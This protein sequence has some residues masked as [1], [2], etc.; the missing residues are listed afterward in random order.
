M[1]AYLSMQRGHAATAKVKLDQA[2]QQETKKKDKA[3]GRPRDQGP[4]FNL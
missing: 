3:R 2:K 1:S 4:D